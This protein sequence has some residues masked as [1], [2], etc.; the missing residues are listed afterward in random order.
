MT[1]ALL[2]ADVNF[3]VAQEFTQ[4]VSEAA[5]GR[6]F[7]NR[8]TRTSSSSASSTRSWST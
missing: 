2:E 6:R 5:V 3:T 7:S 4:K 1:Q 8:S